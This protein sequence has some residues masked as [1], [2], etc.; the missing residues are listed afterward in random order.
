MVSNIYIAQVVLAAIFIVTPLNAEFSCVHDQLHHER[1]ELR[2]VVTN[3]VNT[4]P[5]SGARRYDHT[6][7][8]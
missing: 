7:R 3:Q 5:A 2:Q 8:V 4:P 6:G 1:P